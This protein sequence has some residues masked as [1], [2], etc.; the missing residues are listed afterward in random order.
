MAGRIWT[1]AEDGT[2]RT[3]Y[4]L[5]GPSLLRES[6]PGRTVYAITE[7]ARVLGVRDATRAQPWTA[8]DDRMLAVLWPVLGDSRLAH[9]MGRTFEACRLRA[10]RLGLGPRRGWNGFR[11]GQ[12][13][14][15]R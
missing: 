13:T 9:A 7:R 11:S 14:T 1:A 12:T 15:Y 10:S 2:V 3:F 5:L 8:R 6:L 4:P